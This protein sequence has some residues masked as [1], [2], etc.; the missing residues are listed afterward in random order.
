MPVKGQGPAPSDLVHSQ[1]PKDLEAQAGRKEELVQALVEA[2]DRTYAA[3][4][5]KD[6]LSWTTNLFRL[7]DEPSLRA[8]A[9][10]QGLFEEE[11]AEDEGLLRGREPEEL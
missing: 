4:S 1:T 10:R 8:L 11:V 3:G 6:A 9:Y 7:L 5:S 2:V